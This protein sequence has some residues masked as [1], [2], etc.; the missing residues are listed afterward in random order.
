MHVNPMMQLAHGTAA[1]ADRASDRDSGMALYS[2][3]A[4]LQRSRLSTLGEQ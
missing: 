1:Y 3:G 2:A 4:I